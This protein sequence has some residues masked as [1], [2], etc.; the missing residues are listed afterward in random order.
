MVL[1]EQKVHLFQNKSS[2]AHII[3][4]KSPSSGHYSS[5]IEIKVRVNTR[6]FGKCH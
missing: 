5:A 2:A 3:Q 6:K 1:L 4:T